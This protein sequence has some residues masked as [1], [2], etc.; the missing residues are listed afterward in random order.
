MHDWLLPGVGQIRRVLMFEERPTSR[1]RL[2]A[3]VIVGVFAAVLGCDSETADKAAPTQVIPAEEATSEEAAPAAEA[4]MPA[5]EVA[6]TP[7]YDRARWDD[8]HFKPAIDSATDEQCLDCHREILDMKPRDQSPSGVQASSALAWYQT[9]DTYAGEPETF[10]RRHLVTPLAKRLMNLKC[11]TCHQGSNPRE[12]A[13]TASGRGDSGFTLRKAVNAETVCLRCHAQQNYRVMGLPGP[14]PE[15]RQ[16]VG[17]DCLLCHATV[18]TTRHQVNYLNADAIE[19]A[20]KENTDLCFGCHG[21]RAW[22][23][24][25][26]P[27]PRHAW[28]GMPESIPDWAKDRPTESEARFRPEQLPEKIQ[29]RG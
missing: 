16:A 11:N 14:W 17:D 21:G 7:D 6:P 1:S 15:V 18:R 19:A 4:A 22:Y 29:P 8:I 5:E 2:L 23:S 12:A 9:L 27:Y 20:A 10:H 24:A 3:V 25:T 26:Y 13:P 28:P